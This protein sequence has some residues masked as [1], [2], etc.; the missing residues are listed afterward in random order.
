[1]HCDDREFKSSGEKA[2]GK[3][4]LERIMYM[5]RYCQN[6]TQVEFKNSD[7]VYGEKVLWF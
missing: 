5:G 1:M 2:K 6:E 4:L 3:K 7:S